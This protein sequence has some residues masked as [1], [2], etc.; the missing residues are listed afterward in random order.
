[1]D[2]VARLRAG[3]VKCS[4]MSVRRNEEGRGAICSER[5]ERQWYQESSAAVCCSPSGTHASGEE[6]RDFD[7]SAIC[8]KRKPLG[9]LCDFGLRS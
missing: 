5:T 4:R 9:S 6:N 2:A 1:M 8:E 3:I 7:P